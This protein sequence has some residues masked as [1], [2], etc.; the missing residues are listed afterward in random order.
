MLTSVRCCQGDPRWTQE[1][2]I[3]LV[4]QFRGSSFTVGEVEEDLNMAATPESPAV[5]AATPESPAVMA[6]TP[7]SPAVMAAIPE[8]SAFL[9]ATPVFPA[10][11]Y[12]AP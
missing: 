7:E 8:A 5:M 11:M 2:Y 12:I 1:Q 6:A 3:D 4:L 9:D 10:V